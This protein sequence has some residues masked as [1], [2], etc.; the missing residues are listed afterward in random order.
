[1]LVPGNLTSHWWGEMYWLRR[2]QTV[3]IFFSVETKNESDENF[4]LFPLFETHPDR[5]LKV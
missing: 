2:M 3:K 5:Y 1:M 4:L